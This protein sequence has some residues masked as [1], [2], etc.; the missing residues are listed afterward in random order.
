MACR[1]TSPLT[2]GCSSPLPRGL[3]GAASTGCGTSPQQ[4]S[5]PRPMGWWRGCTGRWRTP[6]MPGVAPPPGRIIYR[7]SCW[8][9]E[10]P[11]RR[12]L[13]HQQG[14]LLWGTCWRSQVSCWPPQHRQRTHQCRQRSSPRPSGP[15]LRPL[16][17]L[18][19]ME[20]PTSTY[21]AVVWGCRWRTTTRTPTWCRRR[22]QRCSSCSWER[23]R[24]WWAGTG[25]S[26]AWGRHHQRWRIR[27]AG[28]G[29]LGG[30]IRSFFK[31]SEDLRGVVLRFH[32]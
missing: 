14:R 22:G 29:H 32:V 23:G 16:P 12:S 2:G 30:E 9:S 4:L 20:L 26:P 15:T 5:T 27:H 11:P 13:A 1:P 3:T 19:W 28:G 25:W 8:A 31:T 7:G 17:S 18:P 24:R 21:S 10:L 6:Y